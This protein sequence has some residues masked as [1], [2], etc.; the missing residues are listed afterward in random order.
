MRGR[1]TN[2]VACTAVCPVENVEMFVIQIFFRQG[3]ALHRTCSANGKYGCHVNM[4]GKSVLSTNILRRKY[5]IQSSCTLI[6]KRRI[7][8]RNWRAREREKLSPTVRG[9]RSRE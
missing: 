1:S 5:I 6:W 9:S 2:D 7:D 8:K 4:L 3:C